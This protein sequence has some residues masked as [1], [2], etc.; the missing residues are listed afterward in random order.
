MARGKRGGESVGGWFRETFTA[1]KDLLK[2]GTNAE[3]I[4]RWLKDHPGQDMDGRVKGIMANVKSQMRSKFKMGKLRGKKR[5][6][7][8]A[9]GAVVGGGTM[10]AVKPRTRLSLDDLEGAID[11]CM[12]MAKN[13]NRERLVSVLQHLRKARNLVV[14]EGGER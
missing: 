4:V 1:N 11:D 8:G 7:A 10:V 3:V 13:I 2:S 9:D 6:K 12:T 14:Y 5:R